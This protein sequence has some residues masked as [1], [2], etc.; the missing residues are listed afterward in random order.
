MMINNIIAIIKGKESTLLLL[1]KEV[2]DNLKL[3][4]H[5]LMKFDIKNGQLV[6]SKLDNFAENSNQGGDNDHD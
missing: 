5:N 2:T 4:D 6:V 1:P 3:E